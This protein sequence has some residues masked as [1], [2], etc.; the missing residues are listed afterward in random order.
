MA[1]TK[2]H[3]TPD[4]APDGNVPRL[5]DDSQVRLRKPMIFGKYELLA[6]LRTGGMAEVF[7]AREETHKSD[8][9]ALKRILPSFTDEA[10]YVAMFVDEAQLALRLDHPG[11]VR[12]LETGRVEDSDYIA[13]EYVHGVDVGVL[14]RAARE[15]DKPLP[16][17]LACHITRQV[18]DA[19]EYAHTLTDGAGA[20]LG[21]VHRDVSPQNILVSHA[22]AVKL[23]DFGIAKS[24]E[25]LMRTQA[26]LLKGKYGYL[27]PEQARG[28]SELDCRSDIFTLG[29]CL[30][31]MLT[32]KR[33]FEGGS[34]FSTLMMV[35]KCEVPELR[36]FNPEVPEALLEIVGKALAM[37]SEDRYQSA[38]ELGSALGA[39]CEQERLEADAD[40]LGAYVLEAF[41]H[42]AEGADAAEEEDPTS[43][44]PVT[45][46]LDAFEDLDPVSTV[47]TLAELPSEQP[48]EARAVP[49][50]AATPAPPPRADEEVLDHLTGLLEIPEGEE[51]PPPPAVEAE[52]AAE[53]E[54]GADAVEPPRGTEAVGPAEQTAFTEGAEQRAFTEGAEQSAFTEGTEP[55]A[56]A[57]GELGPLTAFDTQDL[58][59][60][61]EVEEVEPDAAEADD[62][63]ADEER[64]EDT[65]VVAYEPTEGGQVSDDEEEEPT[66][67]K[68]EA[69]DEEP[70]AALGDDEEG[71]T[72]LSLDGEPDDGEETSPTAAAAPADDPE[73]EPST[74][75]GTFQTELGAAAAS[76][77]R[78]RANT[79]PGLGMD[80]DDEEL[81]TQIY[82]APEG[83]AAD[84]G[85]SLPSVPG[86]SAPGA[87][88]PGT[89]SVPG[90]PSPFSTSP[91]AAPGAAVAAS[92]PVA[93]P[94]ASAP[95]GMTPS[96]APGTYP[97]TAS[98]TPA[99]SY[100]PPG[101]DR[102]TL[103]WVGGLVVV[104]VALIFVLATLRQPVAGTI[105]VT[106]QPADAQVLL[107]GAPVGGNASPF[108]LT[109]VSPSEPHV[110]EVR[111]EGYVTW[112]TKLTLRSAQVV[113]LPPVQLM[114]EQP[115]PPKPVAAVPAPAP[116]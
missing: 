58:E 51:E 59:G 98:G 73:Q 102:R 8:F 22:G 80:W 107:D 100:M 101:S 3:T 38:A 104:I 60:A 41:P 113:T 74:D 64:G 27:S 35:R 69:A 68:S 53:A 106:T 2:S 50:A 111:K 88:S 13:L 92:A 70:V 46:L 89:S 30:W 37:G 63:A 96:V 112:K 21:V 110:L 29:I 108:V 16:V 1:D 61:E 52:A 9:V 62:D 6:R 19:L 78:P 90:A 28:L 76:G 65:N 109:E 83:E 54:A 10:D 85:I 97:T 40:K 12:A 71:S 5:S 31:E 18:C 24:S 23:I 56:G 114:S 93:V 47:S 45:G 48:P 66:S 7:K 32:A 39:F 116:A 11:I 86:V 44:D 57:A 72:A 34:D 77:E 26:G 103:M 55:A 67:P 17:D 82:D 4:P 14:L 91:S 87:T 25:Q 36:D 49:A 15:A 75:S 94:H 95:P 84:D 115:E 81:S 33:L 105:H 42:L 79:M 43:G 99:P 20:P